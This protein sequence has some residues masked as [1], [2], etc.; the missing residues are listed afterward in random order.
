L[1]DDPKN[2]LV[3]VRALLLEHGDDLGVDDDYKPDLN[4]AHV[5]SKLFA[6]QKPSP[7]KFEGVR[8]VKS[9][10]VAVR[11]IAWR[12]LWLFEEDLRRPFNVYERE[13][14]KYTKF[15]G[16]NLTPEARYKRRNMKRKLERAGKIEARG[17]HNAK[18][19][20]RD[21]T[22]DHVAFELGKVYYRAT[23]NLPS[24][25]RRPSGT[26][27]GAYVDLVSDFLKAV[28]YAK[29]SNKQFRSMIDGRPDEKGIRELIEI[30]VTKGA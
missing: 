14:K 7:P 3:D 24:Y 12:R 27:G 25:T 23:R 19:F 8:R 4:N 17:W 16:L 29:L 21:R 28:K 22:P 2:L 5:R 11:R 13:N 30:L 18:W 20:N 26:L 9:L 15:A 10:P 6:N 1:A